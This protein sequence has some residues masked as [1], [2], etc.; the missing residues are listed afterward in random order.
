MQRKKAMA[1]DRSKFKKTDQEKYLKS[2]EKDKAAK[3]SKQ[4]WLVS[5]AAKITTQRMRNCRN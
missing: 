2:V 4:D 1:K 3:L 5:R